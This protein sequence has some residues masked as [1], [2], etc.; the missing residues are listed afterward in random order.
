MKSDYRG[1]RRDYVEGSLSRGDLAAEPLEQFVKWMGDAK[2]AEIPDATAMSLATADAAGR[3]AV[4][5]VL[6]KEA[7]PEGFSWFT[8]KR[9]SKGS[10]LAAND[11]A[12]LLF[13]WRELSR[14]IRVSG[15]VEELPDADADEY[16]S[17]RPEGSRFS[18][19]SSLQ[20]SVVENRQEMEDRV[21]QLRQQYPNGDVP[22][23]EKWGG[24]R[25]IPEHFE[26]WQG[27]ESRLHD[28]FS[29]LK[30]D[31]GWSIQRLSP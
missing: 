16:F 17:A 2:Q 9:S 21:S 1:D 30:T 22:R 3:P 24:Y 19:A 12:E 15:R 6:L 28:R 14:Q 10:Q 31:T 29:Y 18:A 26:F 23:P 27:R 13:Y 25:L 4:R 20:G 7:S 11:Q 8:D 5:I